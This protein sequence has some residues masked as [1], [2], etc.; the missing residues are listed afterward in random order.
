MAAKKLA[1]KPVFIGH[2]RTGYFINNSQ[3]VVAPEFC[4]VVG[5]KELL[6]KVRFV[7]TMPIDIAG[8]N[9]TF[10]KTVGL[11]SISPGVYIEEIFVQVTVPIEKNP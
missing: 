7:Y 5:S 3:L 1:I 8:A 4:I 10:A 6:E 9:K 2:P 11:S